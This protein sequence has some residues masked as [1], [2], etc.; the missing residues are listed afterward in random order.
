MSASFADVAI[1]GVAESELGYVPHLSAVELMAQAAHRALANAGLSLKE[2][3]GLFAATAQFQMPAIAAAEQLGISPRY[4][5]SSVQGGTSN[6]SHVRHAIGAIR[7][8]LCEV[9]LVVYG[10]N[11][12]SE[13]KRTGTRPMGAKAPPLET[14]YSPRFPASSY[15]LIAQRHMAQYGTT[16]KQ[17]AEV[18]ISAS[19]WAELN[20]VAF[21]RKPLTHE[22]VLASPV[23]SSPLR[24]LDCCLITDGGGALV[25][26]SSDRARR[27]VEKPIFVAGT[28]EITEHEGVIAMRDLTV[29]GAARTGK[30]AFEASS[31]EP[32]DI[33]VVQIYDAFTINPIVVL[34]DLGFCEKGEGGT[35]VEDGK[36]GPG[37]RFPLNTSG[38]GLSYSH[39]GMFG[40][41][42]VIETVRQLRRECGARQVVGARIG[43]A[44]A[45]GGTMS[46]HCTLILAA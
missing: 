41:F 2:V 20:S 46:T 10:S 38:G 5:D 33:D 16:R 8:G 35:F 12:R 4:L 26:T 13:L 9:A 37:G 27:T 30:Q 32:K 15:A 6:V 24:V 23:V 42:T 21:R 3:D 11:Q 31:F 36:T 45:I 44:H 1:V 29:T 18:A 19:R 28:G 25:L 39:P 34:E 40:I 14:P 43:L 17:L 7:A 22:E